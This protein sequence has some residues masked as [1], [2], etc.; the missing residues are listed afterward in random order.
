MEGCPNGICLDVHW[1]YGIGLFAS[2]WVLCC[3]SRTRHGLE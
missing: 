1:K 3:S 2:L